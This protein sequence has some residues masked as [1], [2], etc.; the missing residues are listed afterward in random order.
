MQCKICGQPLVNIG[1][2]KSSTVLLV[3]EFPGWEELRSGVPWIG[4]AGRVLAKELGRAGVQ[5][6]RCKH[7]NLWRHAVPDDKATKEMEFDYHYT[8]LS[9]ELKKV[10]AV[11]LMGS[12]LAELFFDKKVTTINGCV[13]TSERL[14]SNIEVAI[15]SINPAVCLQR[16]AV[17]GDFR[18]ACQ[19]FAKA[20]KKIRS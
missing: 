20:T 10:K 4:N 9:E 16:E 15:A 17:L 13:M 18:F 19:Q 12:D 7:T 5:F 2:W 8:L 14:P 1:G 3:G 11:F 6:E